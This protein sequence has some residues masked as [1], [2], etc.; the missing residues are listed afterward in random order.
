MPHQPSQVRL[1]S[2]AL[3]TGPT[4]PHRSGPP[5]PA[6]EVS[7]DPTSLHRSGSPLLFSPL[8][9]PALTGPSLGPLII[10]SSGFRRERTRHTPPPPPPPYYQQILDFF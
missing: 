2:P 6:L 8:V 1:P 4:S 7:T 5:L 9:L 10:V 3:S